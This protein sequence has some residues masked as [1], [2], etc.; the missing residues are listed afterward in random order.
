M[1]KCITCGNEYDKCFT[2][3]MAGSTYIFDSFECAVQKLAPL[4]SHC[5]CRVIGHGVEIGDTIYCCENCERAG[6]EKSERSAYPHDR[7]TVV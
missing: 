1:A 2:V 3:L 7:D 6:V 5:G 4:C